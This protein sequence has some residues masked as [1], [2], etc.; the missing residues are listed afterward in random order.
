MDS[1][2][3]CANRWV[4]LYLEDGA[5]APLRATCMIE[6][7]FGAPVL[8][9]VHAGPSIKFGSAPRPAISKQSYKSVCEVWHQQSFDIDA[10]TESFI[11]RTRLA[12][13]VWSETVSACKTR[14]VCA[15]IASIQSLSLALR[16]ICKFE[17]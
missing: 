7:L 17:V 10:D 16:N 15:W 11:A 2:W 4:V 14:N 8:V 13:R 12:S 3:Q 5:F 1:S 6:F 9:G